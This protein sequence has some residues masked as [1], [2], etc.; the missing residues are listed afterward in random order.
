MVLLVTWLPLSDLS[1]PQVACGQSK[2]LQEYSG[3]IRNDGTEPF[4]RNP[5]DLMFYFRHF[6][7]VFPTLA[8]LSII[9]LSVQILFITWSNKDT[10][11]LGDTATLG[12]GR[13][14]VYFHHNRYYKTKSTQISKSHLCLLVKNIAQKYFLQN[15][16]ISMTDP[17]L[18]MCLTLYF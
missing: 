5:P 10:S 8:S 18:K 7:V 15:C 16:I 1:R 14:V 3:I 11:V 4:F 9:S 12:R 6:K 17:T 2:F 13:G